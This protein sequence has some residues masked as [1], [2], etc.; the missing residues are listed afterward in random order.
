MHTDGVTTSTID[1][2]MVSTRLLDLIE[3]CGPV[4]RGDNLSRHSPIFLSLRLGEIPKLQPT[5][6]PPPPR[7]PAWDRAKEEELSA[8]TRQLHER[9]QRVQ[10]P[11]SLLSCRDPLCRDDSHSEQRDNMV[12]DILSTIVETSYTCLP[13][14]GQ[15]GNSQKPD[16]EVIPG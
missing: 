8:Y 6:I 1:H 3:D 14:T 7:M 16:R 2:F 4:H 9:L 5:V 15:A 13:L 12:L 11:N 10:C